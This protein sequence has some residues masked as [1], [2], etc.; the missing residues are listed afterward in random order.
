MHP[1]KKVVE[2]LVQGH[3]F[4]TEEVDEIML[5]NGMSEKNLKEYRNKGYDDDRLLALFRFYV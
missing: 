2:M 3:K 5:F 1:M 4:S